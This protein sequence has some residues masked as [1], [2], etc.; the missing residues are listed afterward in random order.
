MYTYL[1][2]KKHNSCLFY[3]YY[4]NVAMKWSKLIENILEISLFSM[5]W[6]FDLIIVFFILQKNYK[7]TTHAHL[8]GNRKNRERPWR[9]V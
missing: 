4:K 9:K 2:S 3:D 1:L 7:A 8:K 6:F 5:P